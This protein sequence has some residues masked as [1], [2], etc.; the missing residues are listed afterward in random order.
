MLYSLA[1]H[2]GAVELSLAKEL[3]I[4]KIH[5]RSCPMSERNLFHDHPANLPS[6]LTDVLVENRN[7]RIE[8]IVST[9]QASPAEFWY[10]QDQAEW[11]VVLAGEARLLMEGDSEP[12]SLRP[13]DHLLIPA[14][15]KHRVEWT[16]P[17]AATVWLAVFFSDSE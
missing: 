4:L 17:Q 9:G 12:V 16:T 7:V 15:R 2:N 10:D 14:H 8:R 1:R 11:V 5:Q 3:P 13:G 6:E